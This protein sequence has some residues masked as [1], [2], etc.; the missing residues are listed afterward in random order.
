MSISERRNHTAP[1]S[2]ANQVPQCV[3]DFRVEF[4]HHVGWQVTAVSPRA[5]DWARRTM[6]RK[7]FRPA[8]DEPDGVVLRTDLSGINDLIRQARNEGYS[9]EYVGPHEVIR[10]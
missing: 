1:G 10:L 8:A 6:A 2:A 4:S 3:S 5:R 9:S 7:R